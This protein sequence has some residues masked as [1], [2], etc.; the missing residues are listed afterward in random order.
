MKKQVWV[1]I[2]VKVKLKI[3]ESV[4]VDDIINEIDYDFET[5]SDDSKIIDTEM[6]DYDIIYAEP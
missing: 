4:E 3:N 5:T 1:N 6:I 2:T